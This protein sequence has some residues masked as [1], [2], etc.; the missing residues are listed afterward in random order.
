METMTSTH[1]VSAAA[2]GENWRDIAKK[3]LEQI[4]SLR[5]EGF[6]P[7]IGFLY[8]SDPLAADAGSILTLFR[9]VTGV[10][11]WS[12]CAATGVVA[13]GKEYINVP[14]ISALIGQ[15]HEDNV[16]A[17]HSPGEDFRKLRKD[18]EP[19]LNLHDPMLVVLHA[20][21]FFESHP[22]AAIEEIEAMVGGFMVGG[23]ASSK[24]EH[25][26]IGRDVMESGISG[27]VF[28]AD[29]PVATTLSQGCVSIGGFHE[30]SKSDDHVVAYLDGRTPFEVFSEDMKAFAEARLGYKAKEAVL[31]A[32]EGKL[33]E[34]LSQM[35]HGQAL[36]AFPV[37]GTD[38]KDYL[39]RNILAIDPDSG[40][41]AIAEILEDGQNMMF[42]HR[43]DETVR[44]DLS[45][46][47]VALRKRVMHERGEFKPKAGIY[48]SCVARMNVAF[49][50]DGKTGGEMALV[51]EILGDI[52]LAGFYA[53][54]EIS[55]NRLYGYTGVLTLFL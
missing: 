22:A 27:F 12:G 50:Q 28:S 44:S 21:P 52:P 16:R 51:R 40:A 30:V 7:N 34:Q 42:V 24:Q 11:H 43:D 39:V 53:G 41:M 49:A 23:L 38:Q 35:L 19:W 10:Q 33:P 45:A 25:A 31:G 3:V 32:E 17:F 55:N 13:N 1:F 20:D 48:V 46:S 5:T 2:S 4:E 15:V 6:K 14:A 36:A 18:M 47:L 37:S 29:V 26:V 8:I 9:S 54:G